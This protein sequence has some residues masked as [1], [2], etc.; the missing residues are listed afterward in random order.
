M[1]VRLVVVAL[2]VAQMHSQFGKR[3]PHWFDKTLAGYA[4][5]YDQKHEPV[6]IYDPKTRFMLL[7]DVECDGADLTLLL[8]RDRYEMLQYGFLAPDF[9]PA[10]KHDEGQKMKVKPLTSLSTGKGVTIGD[11]PEQTVAKLGRPKK[12]DKTGRNKQY[13]NYRYSWTRGRGEDGTQYDQTYTFKGGKLIEVMF[14]WG[15][16]EGYEDLAIV[17]PKATAVSHSRKRD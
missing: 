6:A 11:S 5:A 2:S 14:T 16:A 15:P 12:I 7:R 17:R 10:G 13:L 9:R 8:T 1:L 4:F 3:L